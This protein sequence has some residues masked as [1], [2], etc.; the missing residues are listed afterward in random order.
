M[1]KSPYLKK[2]FNSLGCFFSEKNPQNNWEMY[3]FQSWEIVENRIIGLTL[4]YNILGLSLK[5]T[6]TL[7]LTLKF[8]YSRVQCTSTSSQPSDK[9]IKY[10]P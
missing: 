7:N 9:K 5:L 2:Y 4:G 3:N 8:L 10:S 6:E 1:N